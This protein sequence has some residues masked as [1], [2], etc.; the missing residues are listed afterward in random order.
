MASISAG[1]PA[2]DF[3]LTD[4]NGETVTLS[5]YR[6][7]WVVAYFYPKDDTPGCT[8]EACSFRDSYE[9]FVDVGAEVIGISAQDE[10]SKKK[11]AEKYNLPF[12]LVADTG[13][14]IRKAYGVPKTMGL[15]PGRVTYVIDPEGI[16][17]KVF[18]SQS[19]VLKHTGEA[20]ATINGS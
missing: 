15:L 19:G 7:K 6:G 13:N 20:L 14:T 2:P 5:D 10:A 9:D 3:T 12:K 1:D 11:F 18:N 4:Q 16:V 17:R 8:R